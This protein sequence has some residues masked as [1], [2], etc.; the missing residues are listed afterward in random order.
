MLTSF[1]QDNIIKRYFRKSIKIY[2]LFQLG[3]MM[4]LKSEFISKAVE[5]VV[6][7]AAGY[8]TYIKSAPTSDLAAMF[9]III[10]LMATL[11]V[12]LLIESYRHAQDISDT[13]LR[14][15]NLTQRIAERHQDTWDF[16]QTLRYGVTTIPSEQWIDVFMQL[17]WRIK[18]RLLATNYV[19]PEEGW[20]RAYGELYHEIQRSKIKVNKATISRTFI[21][22]S[23][24]EIAQLRGIMSKQH[25]A[26]IEVKYIHKRDIDRTSILKTGAGSIESL[27]FDIF[28]DKLVWLTLVDRNRKIK[29][30]KILFGKEEC[31]RYKRFHD[32]L[33]AEAK[34]IDFK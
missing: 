1:L 30:G 14:L 33:F 11:V 18:Y 9:G 31:E 12:A 15:T 27:D 17:L 2:A 6:G 7:V 29:Y 10:G 5:I 24:N 20:G 32:H 16:V 21:V 19:S 34:D 8:I 4:D 28:D 23:K 3:G 25:Q 26:G 13:N 22:D